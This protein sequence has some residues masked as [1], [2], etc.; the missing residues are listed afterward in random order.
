MSSRFNEQDILRLQKKGLVIVDK[1]MDSKIKKAIPAEQTQPQRG[2]KEK[3][4]IKYHLD[5]TGLKIEEEYVFSTERKFRFDFCIIKKKIA[6]EYEGIFAGKSRHTTI[7]GY[8]TDCDKYN[9][10][11]VEGWRVLRYTAKNYRN[12]EQDLKRIL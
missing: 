3:L 5:Q 8:T 11:A 1:I 4:F 9:L 12:I 2:K 6:F 7:Q 10:A